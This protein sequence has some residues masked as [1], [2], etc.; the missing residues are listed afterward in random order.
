MSVWC[1]TGDQDLKSQC[2]DKLNQSFGILIRTFSKDVTPRVIIELVHN[3]NDFWC[4]NIG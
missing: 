4:S 3:F 1:H 2:Y